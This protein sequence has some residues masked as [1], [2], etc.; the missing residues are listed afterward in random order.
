[1]H[2][3]SFEPMLSSDIKQKVMKRKKLP[4]RNYSEF[5][6][7]N[8]IYGKLLNQWNAV[9]QRLPRLQNFIPWKRGWWSFNDLIVTSQ[10]KICVK[11]AVGCVWNSLKLSTSYHIFLLNNPGNR[12]IKSWCTRRHPPSCRPL[13]FLVRAGGGA[14]KLLRFGW[15][16]QN[17]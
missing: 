7:L 13:F 2:T 12:K 9:L 8:S 11:P 5:I 15:K 14:K 1:M 3:I 17:K 16:L 6:A 4:Y 10:K